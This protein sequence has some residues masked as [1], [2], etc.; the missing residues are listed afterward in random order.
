M[1]DIINVAGYGGWVTRTVISMCYTAPVSILLTTT[2]HVGG[3]SVI[4][5][6]TTHCGGAARSQ[7]GNRLCGHS[8]AGASQ[9]GHLVI[10]LQPTA[11][12]KS[13][14]WFNCSR[15]VLGWAGLGWAGIKLI[16][17]LAPGKY[18]IWLHGPA[19]PRAA[20]PAPGH[21]SPLCGAELGP[22]EVQHKLED[23]RL[24]LIISTICLV[25]IE[26]G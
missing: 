18:F 14:D 7:H 2:Y 1:P 6:I 5:V 9:A 12:V 25:H 21:L 16:N 10:W 11:G 4:I 19:P 17:P 20:A 3:S 23:G 24:Q 15:A 22:G 8:V 13:P 26:M